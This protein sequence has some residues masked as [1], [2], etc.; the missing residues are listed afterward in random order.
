MGI[1]FLI[2]M[3]FNIIRGFLIDSKKAAPYTK[4]L[5]RIR[6]YLMLLFPVTMYPSN[7]TGDKAIDGIKVVP[8]AKQL[9]AAA[10]KEN[11]FDLKSILG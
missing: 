4:W 2:E 8:V 5:L 3:L 11:G 10:A 6:D 7:A 9:V 1:S